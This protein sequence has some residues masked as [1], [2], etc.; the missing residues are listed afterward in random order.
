[1]FYVIIWIFL[2]ILAIFQIVSKLLN[3]FLHCFLL[4][5][6]SINQLFNDSQIANTIFHSERNSCVLLL[7]RD[8][9]NEISAKEKFLLTLSI[10][11]CISHQ[12]YSLYLLYY[13]WNFT[14]YS[15]Y[16]L[17]YFSCWKKKKRRIIP[18]TYLMENII[19]NYLNII[20]LIRKTHS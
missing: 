20:M 13:F 4:F 5:V 2:S 1:M 10:E 19:F 18:L 12:F 3:Y 8:I 6:E 11:I 15:L 17:Y 16:L 7:K 14:N 9:Q